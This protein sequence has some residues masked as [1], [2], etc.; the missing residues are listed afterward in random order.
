[1][2]SPGGRVAFEKEGQP[3]PSIC[4]SIDALYA[5]ACVEVDIQIHGTSGQG[6][7]NR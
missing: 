5:V 7:T 4:F 6:S 1:M 3:V 2:L